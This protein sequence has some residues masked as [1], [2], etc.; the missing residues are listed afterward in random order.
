MSKL[1]VNAPSGDQQLIQ[2]GPGSGYF[3]ESRVI[4]DERADGPLPEI[5]LGGMVRSG[6]SLVFDQDR[7]DEHTEATRPPVPQSVTRRQARQALL[8]A[9]LLDNV[10]PALDAI[11]DATQRRL[12]QIEWDDSLEFHRNRPALLALA[13]ALGLNS[14][15]IDQLF[16][17]AAGL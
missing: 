10:Q 6:S 2:V 12:M 3:D 7:M 4:W 14:S 1:L 8:L 11:P 15:Q 17:T 16:I 5:T 13:G 9:G